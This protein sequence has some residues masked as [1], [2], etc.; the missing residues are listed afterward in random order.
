[1]KIRIKKSAVQRFIPSRLVGTTQ[2]VDAVNGSM[3]WF[4]PEGYTQRLCLH[5]DHVEIVEEKETCVACGNEM[6]CAGGVNCSNCGKAFCD[7][8]YEANTT[9]A[10]DMNFYCLDCGGCGCEDCAEKRK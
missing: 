2:K 6:P 7:K 4:Q 3:F 1:M 8:C 10:D 9:Y 5:K